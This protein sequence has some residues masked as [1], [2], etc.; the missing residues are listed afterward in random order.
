M[1]PFN[2]RTPRG[3]LHHGPHH[4]RDARLFPGTRPCRGG[5]LVHMQ[6]T[7]EKTS[8][9]LLRRLKNPDDQ[10]SW[11]EFVALYEP[12]LVRYVRKKGLDEHN[13][14]DVVQNIFVTLL[15]TLPN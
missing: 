6:P 3:R 13:A 11:G 7:V 10:A 14:R 2:P 4:R 12:L 15:R 8:S 9:S 1:L 5:S